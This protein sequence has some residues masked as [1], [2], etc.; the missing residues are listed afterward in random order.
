MA[1]ILEF[2]DRNG[3]V[4]LIVYVNS[5]GEVIQAEGWV[6]EPVGESVDIT[7]FIKNSEYWKEKIE[8]KLLDAK[9]A[10]YE[11]SAYDSWQDS[12]ADGRDTE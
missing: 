12:L 9:T 4:G 10:A 2:P 1:Y 8:E 11:N 5:D 7:P 6:V 3:E